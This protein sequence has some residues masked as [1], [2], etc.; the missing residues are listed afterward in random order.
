MKRILIGLAAASAFAI[1]AYA[2]EPAT[3]MDTPLGKILVGANQMTL[4]TYDKDTK[5]ADTSA[6]KGGCIANWP[7]FVA[8]E[9]AAPE[10]EWTIVN[11]T[12][13]DGAAKKMWAYD[14][15]PLYYYVKD[16]KAG[17]TTGDGAG[18]VWHIVKAD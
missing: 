18:G 12:D 5:G 4:Y 11:V 16:A 17:D 3:S 7:P 14:G 10:G 9:G 13:K 2:A 6:C 15:W 8:E 1:A